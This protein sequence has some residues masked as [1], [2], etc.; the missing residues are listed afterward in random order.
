MLLLFSWSYI[1]WR[2]AEKH[3]TVVMVLLDKSQL[4][5]LDEEEEGFRLYGR[6]AAD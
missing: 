5:Q 4:I 6:W 1:S 2:L 3:D